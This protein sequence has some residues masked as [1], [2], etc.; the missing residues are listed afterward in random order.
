[1][2]SFKDSMMR[3]LAMYGMSSTTQYGRAN[4][5]TLAD[6]INEANKSAR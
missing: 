3:G 4:D 1:M 5:T 2:M 6:L